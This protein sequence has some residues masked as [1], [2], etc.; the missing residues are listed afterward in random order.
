MN[1]KEYDDFINNHKYDM[2]HF[3]IYYNLKVNYDLGI[4]Q[5]TNEEITKLIEL[6]WSSYM[7]D[8][9][10][11]DLSFICDKLVENV[12]KI[13]NGNWAKWDLLGV[14]YE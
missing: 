13:I 8:E 3:V 9:Q 5:L 11:I 7:A 12:E 1:F 14:C 4:E 2:L 6:I 10:H